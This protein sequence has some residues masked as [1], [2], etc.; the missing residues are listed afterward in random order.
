MKNLLIMRHAK[1]DWS[2]YTTADFD[3]PLNKRGVKDAPIMGQQLLEMGKK[4]DL[5]ISSSAN[6]AASTAQLVAQS[7]NYEDY[8]QF[9]RGF[10]LSDADDIMFTVRQISD[11]YDTVLVIG[12][13]PT[14][15]SLVYNLVADK[16][17]ILSIPT[18]AIAS[19]LFEVDQWE[20]V[21]NN[22]G[23]LEFFIK[24]KYFK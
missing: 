8:I 12:H 9:E 2:D 15:E 14:M 22:I 18:A 11:K 6:R 17:S 1:S 19:I 23:K 10:Y 13:N 5:I 3:R 7:I 4:V 16:T 24:P 21:D 20:Y